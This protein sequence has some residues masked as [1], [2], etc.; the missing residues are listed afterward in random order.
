MVVVV[1]S[2]PSIFTLCLLASLARFACSLASPVNSYG[3]R[4]LVFLG[5]A[6]VM[7]W[8][9]SG[10]ALVMLWLCSGYALVMLWLCSGYALVM[11]WVCSGYALVMLWLCS[12]YALVMLWLCSGYALV[13]LW[14]CSGYRWCLKSNVVPPLGG[15]TPRSSAV[16]GRY[17]LRSTYT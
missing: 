7:L 6:L 11:L 12:G 10:Y 17:P 9:C 15:G 13:M 1:I 14:L 2:P 5:Y 8:L 4:P 16:G 3:C